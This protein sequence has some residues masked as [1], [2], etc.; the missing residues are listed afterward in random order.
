[1]QV[2]VERKITVHRFFR[3]PKNTCL[4]I[5]M[6]NCLCCICLNSY[7]Y[8]YVLWQWNKKSRIL[9]N[10]WARSRD[11]QQHNAYLD[12]LEENITSFRERRFVS[13]QENNKTNISRTLMWW[14]KVDERSLF[15]FVFSFFSQW[16][17][18]AYMKVYN[19]RS[20]STCP[21]SSSFFR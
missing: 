18:F 14:E 6:Y 1:M 7:T 16:W 20:K 8:S 10:G 11:G 9:P 21:S 4:N 13:E 3:F 15:F 2:L 12:C 5:L 17:I 19:T